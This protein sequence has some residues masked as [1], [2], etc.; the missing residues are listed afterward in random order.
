MPAILV[1]FDTKRIYEVPEVAYTTTVQAGG[2][3]RLTPDVAA[4]VIVEYDLLADIYSPWVRDRET[5]DG[6][7]A[8]LA[9]RRSGG[10][11]IKTDE[12][13]TT[14]ATTELFVR[15]DYGWRLV[16]ANYEHEW[17]I[18][19][20]IRRQDLALPI[21]DF[22]GN[23]VI[24]AYPLIQRAADL[25]VRT[26]VSG[27]GSGTCLFEAE[28]VTQLAEVHSWVG[29]MRGWLESVYNW[30]GSLFGPTSF[31][32]TSPVPFLPPVEYVMGE[33]L[34]LQVQR[35]VAAWL[36]AGPA[37]KVIYSPVD[38]G[39]EPSIAL[40]EL[41]APIIVTPASVLVNELQSQ[42]HRDQKHGRQLQT[43]RTAWL[44]L[45]SACGRPG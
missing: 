12:S 9:F 8:P 26:V 33:P 19:G 41:D 18:L 29:S 43:S 17:R 38:A 40:D 44:P 35:K 6:D 45:P 23:S 28:Q 21:F 39:L 1:D 10:D 37:Y 11:I 14:S 25:L 36:K 32:G 30:I 2:I 31:S 16:P 5:A 15:N 3:L 34:R 20:N 4:P 7:Y 27:G 13:G 24:G 42:F 22:S